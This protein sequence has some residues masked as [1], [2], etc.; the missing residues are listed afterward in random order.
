MP[1]VVGHIDPGGAS[2]DMTHP[3]VQPYEEA[4]TLNPFL[5]TTTV[6]LKRQ[7]LGVDLQI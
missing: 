4:E 1:D 2:P 6:D 5:T 3:P 7:S